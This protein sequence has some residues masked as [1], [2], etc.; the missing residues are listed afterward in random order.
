MAL[1]SK[2]RSDGELVRDGD[3]MNRIMPYIMRKRNESA[4]L[5]PDVNR[6]DKCAKLLKKIAK[7]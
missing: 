1:F 4:V 7:W 6:S 3:P 2:K 5:L